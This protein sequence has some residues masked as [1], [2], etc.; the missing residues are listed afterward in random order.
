L[1][2][3]RAD[4]DRPKTEP[5]AEGGAAR[6]RRRSVRFPIMLRVDYPLAGRNA[7]G[8]TANLSR[9][10]LFLRGSAR[11]E[12]GAQLRLSVHLGAGQE[13]VE[14]EAVV[15]SVRAGTAPGLGLEFLPRQPR[16]LE[17]IH[18]FIAEELVA[19]HEAA[20]SRSPGNLGAVGLIAAWYLETDRADEA[21]QL[22]RRAVEANPAASAPY[23]G[24]LRLLV[25][26]VRAG[27]KGAPPLAE[28]EALL[29]SGLAAGRT[30]GLLA[31]EREVQALRRAATQLERE[32]AREEEERRKRE[33]KERQAK[34]RSALEREAKAQA[35]KT[36]AARRRELERVLEARVEE[37]Q[38]AA[39]EERKA[40]R[41]ERAEVARLAEEQRERDAQLERQ[42]RKLEQ[43]AATL[44][45]ERAA[46]LAEVERGKE[47]AAEAARAAREREK[48]LSGRLAGIAADEQ[49]AAERVKAR[50]KE[51]AA[52]E[53]ELARQRG[54]LAE[55][56]KLQAALE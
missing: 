3:R 38:Q 44:E 5:E 54:E 37:A 30:A 46:L 19:K 25:P 49:A 36:L 10:G 52:Q 16:A 8:Y 14:V 32:R 47:S 35:E 11:I 9:A 1:A 31:L 26:R 24:L 15:R 48:E 6:D 7:F 34:L 42:Q 23:E 27:A 13:P 2:S 41:A 39:A 50:Q 53:R 20:L 45:E 33:E 40:L 18:R 4:G 17:A 28:A 55:A 51:L 43:R 56:E 12:A 22:Y 21:E 29:E